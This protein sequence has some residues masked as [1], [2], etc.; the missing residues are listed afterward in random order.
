MASVQCAAA[1]GC[2]DSESCCIEAHPG[3][4]AACGLSAAEAAALMAAGVG[5]TGTHGGAEAWDDAHNAHLP[6]WKRRCIRAY[7][8]CQEFKWSGN[9]HSCFRYCE[10]QQEWPEDQCGPRRKGR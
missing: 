5:A 1:G 3:N 2:L 8:D 9:C 10:G 7:G 4:P 6:D